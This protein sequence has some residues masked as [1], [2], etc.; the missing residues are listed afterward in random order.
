MVV[1]EL[2]QFLTGSDHSPL[3]VTLNVGAE[4]DDV[5][6][7]Q[8]IRVPNPSNLKRIFFSSNS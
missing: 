6:V 8:E 5:P 2:N 3:I 1:D 4:G 7:A